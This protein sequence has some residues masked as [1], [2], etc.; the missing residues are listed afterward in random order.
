VFQKFGL[1]QGAN[2]TD[3]IY[4]GSVSVDSA[5]HRFYEPSNGRSAFAGIRFRL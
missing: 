1:F 5:I 2:L 4:S 3:R